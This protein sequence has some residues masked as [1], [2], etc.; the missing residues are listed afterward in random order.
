[1]KPSDP[2]EPNKEYL[3]IFIASVHEAALRLIEARV[4][5]ARATGEDDDDDNADDNDR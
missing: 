2:R 1:M 4:E 5:E 3:E